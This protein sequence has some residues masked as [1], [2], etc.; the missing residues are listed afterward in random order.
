VA[1]HLL[2]FFFSVA[3]SAETT[4]ATDEVVCFPTADLV[5][6]WGFAAPPAPGPVRHH[7]RPQHRC[8][9]RLMTALN[10]TRLSSLAC[11]QCD[12][13]AQEVDLQY[14]TTPTSTHKCF[15]GDRYLSTLS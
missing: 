11:D 3:F 8:L 6:R 7:L 13:E 1:F 14:K 2:L 15:W 5:L 12:V 9:R 4:A 10:P